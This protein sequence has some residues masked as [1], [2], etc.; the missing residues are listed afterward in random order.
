[1][2][3]DLVLPAGVRHAGEERAAPEPTEDTDSGP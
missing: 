1:V 2:H 3:A